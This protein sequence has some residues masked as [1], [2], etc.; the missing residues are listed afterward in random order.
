MAGRA[1]PLDGNR[2]ARASRL[3]NRARDCVM[4]GK[5]SCWDTTSYPLLVLVN[6]GN[7][8]QDSGE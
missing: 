7:L 2:S 5:T 4:G 3:L 1:R 6:P 8:V